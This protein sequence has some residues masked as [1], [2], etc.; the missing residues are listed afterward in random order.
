[1]LFP[2]SHGFHCRNN[3]LTRLGKIIIRA[4]SNLTFRLLKTPR[5]IVK[6]YESVF[7]GMDERRNVRL[8]SFL[9]YLKTPRKIVKACENVFLGM[10][11]RRNVR[12]T[13]DELR[14]I[15]FKEEG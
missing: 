5:K 1:M 6:A 14:E 10:D 9:A 15:F 2:F 4:T 8:I 13:N 12:P 11:E 7:L 3:I